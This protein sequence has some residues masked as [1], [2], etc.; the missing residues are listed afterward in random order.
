MFFF[1]ANTAK[2]PTYWQAGLFERIS[3]P[4]ALLFF[5]LVLAGALFGRWLTKKMSDKL[6]VQVVYV[7][8]FGLGA[9]LFYIGLAGLL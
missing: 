5:P 6:F 9:Y 8:V 1:C 4:F 7:T 3:V 2:L